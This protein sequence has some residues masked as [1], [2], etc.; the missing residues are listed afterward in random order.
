MVTFSI[1]V[2]KIVLRY[3][4][5]ETTIKTVITLQTLHRVASLKVPTAMNSIQ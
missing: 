5:K 3:M 2:G 4:A 1:S